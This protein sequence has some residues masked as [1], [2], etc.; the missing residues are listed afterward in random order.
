MPHEFIGIGIFKVIFDKEHF[1]EASRMPGVFLWK[2]EIFSGLA[3]FG[4]KIK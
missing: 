2:N 4:H 1:D 3:V